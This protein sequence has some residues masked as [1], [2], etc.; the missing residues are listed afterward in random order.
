M[1]SLL[2]SSQNK[3]LVTVAVGKAMWDK[4]DEYIAKIAEFVDELGFDMTIVTDDNAQGLIVS[5]VIR[6]GN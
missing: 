4:Y 5:K 2:A 3:H 1:K 6:H